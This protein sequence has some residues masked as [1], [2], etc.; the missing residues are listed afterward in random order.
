MQLTLFRLLDSCTALPE[1]IPNLKTNTVLPVNHGT[2]V[3]VKCEVGYTLSGS[4]LITC[5]KDKNWEYDGNPPQCTLGGFLKKRSILLAR[6][7]YRT[8]S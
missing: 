6:P 8:V 1:N 7:E 2:S 5:N 4:N 3:E